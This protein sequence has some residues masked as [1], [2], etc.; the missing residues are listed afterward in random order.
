M[1]FLIENARRV[2]IK[3]GTG[4][5]TSGKNRMDLDRIRGIT[6]QVAALREKGLEVLIVSSG[7]VGLGMGQLGLNKRPADL[8]A[9]QAC[10]AV[11]QTI[12]INTWQTLFDT[13]DIK[14][15]QILLTHDDVSGRRRHVAIKDTLEKLLSMGVI[16]IVNENDSVNAEEIKFGD[17][18]ILSALVAILTKS[19][20]LLILSTIPGL[21]DRS[22]SG[23]LVPLVEKITPEIERM[24]EDTKSI[25]SV[26]GMRTK[27]AAAKQAADSGCGVFIGSGLEPKLLTRLFNGQASGTYFMP[28][29]I[30]MHS[31]KRWI[32]FFER[33]KGTVQVDSGARE[34]LL[35]KGS[36][37]LAS[38]VTQHTDQF[39]SGDIINIANSDGSVFARGISQFDSDEL[40]LISGKKTGEI[41]KIFPE[42][43]RFEVIHRDSLAL[44]G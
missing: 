36:S 27:I 28:A 20:M 6:D 32:A 8:P 9:L 18:D 13:H 2:T 43:K 11:G 25:T 22:G 24:A 40:A 3:L 26:G 33:P 35:E 37:L 1:Q 42:R 12:L 19:D 21:L 7:A 31:K 44:L 10:A 5:L 14:V 30:D 38:G 17:N 39:K 23:D 16:P 29:S 34:A 4:I 41:R 15:A